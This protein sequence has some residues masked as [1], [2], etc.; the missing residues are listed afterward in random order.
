MDRGAWLATVHGGTKSW[1]Q[2]SNT[3]REEPDILFGGSRHSFIPSFN[4]P[5]QYHAIS[6]TF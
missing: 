2:L 3:L 6:I 4:K 5:S 1:T